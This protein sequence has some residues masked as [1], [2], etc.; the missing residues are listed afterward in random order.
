MKAEDDSVI[1]DNWSARAPIGGRRDLASSQHQRAPAYGFSNRSLKVS[2][3][4]LRRRERKRID[5]KIGE[6]M[7]GSRMLMVWNPLESHEVN[8]YHIDVVK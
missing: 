2:G 1:L 8:I 6:H 5:R 7:V 3:L 4:K